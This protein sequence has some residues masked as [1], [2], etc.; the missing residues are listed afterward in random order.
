MDGRENNLR[1]FMEGQFTNNEVQT[2]A[3]QQQ[4]EHNQGTKTLVVWSRG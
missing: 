1:Y 4:G 2:R 3:R